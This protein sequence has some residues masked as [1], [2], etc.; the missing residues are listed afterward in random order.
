M[1]LEKETME[2]SMALIGRGGEEA[3][4]VERSMAHALYTTRVLGATGDSLSGTQWNMRE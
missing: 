3:T 4:K 2:S 1:G